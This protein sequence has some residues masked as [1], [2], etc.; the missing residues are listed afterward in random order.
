M[1]SKL[2]KQVKDATAADD[3]KPRLKGR[4]AVPTSIKPDRS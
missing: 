2:L 3:T 1:Q 4:N